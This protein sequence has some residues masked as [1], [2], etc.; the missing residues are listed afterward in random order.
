M[1]TIIINNQELIINDTIALDLDDNLFTSLGKMVDKEAVVLIETLDSRQ[2]LICD[3]FIIA[4]NPFDKLQVS[5]GLLMEAL[6]CSCDIIDLRD[7][8]SDFA[9]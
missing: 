3:G 2:V 5:I 4:H 1:L 9:C 8:G 7:E 6:D